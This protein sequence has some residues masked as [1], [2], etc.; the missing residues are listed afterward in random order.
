MWREEQHFKMLQLCHIFS[1]PWSIEVRGSSLNK[2]YTK[3]SRRVLLVTYETKC[4]NF[5]MKYNSLQCCLMWR[6][7]FFN[8]FP[9]H[10]PTNVHAPIYSMSPKKL[11]IAIRV[12][13]S[14]TKLYACKKHKSSL[15]FS[16]IPTIFASW[17][18]HQ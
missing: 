17:F 5:R 3:M 11:M 13:A 10:M 14:T 12:C 4:I 7:T 2:L 6:S 8:M 9:E 18:A 15:Y 16:G 1:Q